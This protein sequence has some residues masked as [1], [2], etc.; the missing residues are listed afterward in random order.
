MTEE[1]TGSEYL[2]Q[3]LRDY[4]VGHVF[5]VPTIAVPAL[6]AMDRLGIVGVTAHSEKAAAYMA[7]GYARAL[8]RPGIC[9]AQTV[10]AANLASGLRDAMLA[11]APVVAITGGT[12]PTTRRRGVYQELEDYPA[13]EPY[14]KFNMQLDDVRRLPDLLRQTFREATSGRPGPVHLELQGLLGS[15][16]QDRFTPADADDERKAER[17]HAAVP[18]YRPAPRRADV[19]AAIEAIVTARRPLVIAGGGVRASRAEAELAAFAHTA[20]IPVV[21]SMTAKGAIDE[22]DPLALGVM[23]GASRPSA[24][25]AGERAD[26]VVIVGSTVGSQLTDKFRLPAYGTPVVQIDIEGA[27]I[28]RNHPAD[29]GIQA[30]AAETL[31]A[32]TAAWPSPGPDWSA[33]REETARYVAEFRASA[34]GLQTST[35]TPIRPERILR[36]VTGFLGDDD[37]LVVD[38]GHAA[39]WAA[40]Q[41]DL[42]PSQTFLRAAGHLGW[43]LPAAI[44]AQAAVGEDRTVVAWTG[45][46]GFY[47][48]LAE[49]ETAARYGIAPVIVVNDNVSLSQDMKVFQRAWGGAER[50]TESGDRM[51]RFADVDLAG[52]ARALGAWSARVDDPGDLREALDEA[53][54]MRRIAVLDVRTAP[55]ALPDVPWGGRDYYA[56][57]TKEEGEST[58]ATSRR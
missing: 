33:W 58:W 29:V 37:V 52:A 6:A 56:P 22:H 15:V 42:R 57:D 28:G 32:L 17:R 47:Y 43:S 41:V 9:M 44:G 34:E 40:G 2:A 31:A 54:R 5:M 55:E 21:T 14:T 45:D 18:A 11:H 48:H 27:E 35:D 7:D 26:L 10:G 39:I 25:R 51:W 12:A 46:G 50:I 36:E 19:A 4:G 13:F 38:T 49:I 16:L 20:G 8:G 1:T 53:S 3:A 30:D 23:G 24:N